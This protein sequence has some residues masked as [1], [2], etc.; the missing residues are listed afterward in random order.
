MKCPFCAEEIQPDAIKC[1]HCGEWLDRS[2]APPATPAT[3][4]R[5][6]NSAFQLYAYEVLAPGQRSYQ[7]GI[8]LLFASNPDQA[9]VEANKYIPQGHRLNTERGFWPMPKGRFTCPNCKS[10]FTDSKRAIGCAMGLII[11]VSLGLGLLLIPLL[12]FE[13]VCRACGYQWKP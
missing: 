9:A 10:Q 1:R 2:K 7:G 5:P 11:F 8:Q 3:Q 12:P 6:D 4:S 13:S